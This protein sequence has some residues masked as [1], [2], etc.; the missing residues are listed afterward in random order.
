MSAKRVFWL[1]LMVV[2]C[3]ASMQGQT[4]VAFQG[5]EPGDS[6]SYTAS[7]ASAIGQ[8]EAQSAANYTSGS[9]SIVMGGLT[10][11]GSCLS[12]GSGNG[13][14]ITNILTF[15]EV[16][17]S[18]STN[19]T[20]E[21]TF[22]YGN[23]FPECGGTGF[24]NGENL[25]LIPTFNGVV[26]PAIVVFTGG[27]NATLDIAQTT[28]AFEVPPCVNS[29]SFELQ[30]SLNRN[31]EFLFI[32]DVS[33]STP[34]F[35]DP[36]ALQ[37]WESL[38]YNA[39]TGACEI[40]GSQPEAPVLD[41]NQTAFFNT[42]SC[43][44][45]VSGNLPEEPTALNCWD[46]FLLDIVNCQWVNQGMQPVHPPNLNCW[47]DYLFDSIQCAWVNQGIQPTD[48]AAQNCWDVFTFN[49]ALCQWENIGVQPEAPTDVVCGFTV[50]FSEITCAWEL[51][52]NGPQQ[53]TP[54]HCWDNFILNETTCIWENVGVEPEQPVLA[55]Y[56][57]AV[58][59]DDGCLWDVT[60]DQPQQ[61]ALECYETAVFNEIG[62]LWDVTGNQPQQ[63]TLECYE[64][65]VFDDIGCFWDVFGNQPI[66]PS[67]A[68]YETAVFNDFTCSWEVSGE[69]PEQPS[70]DCGQTASFNSITCSWEVLGAPITL[71]ILSVP[72][73]EF[74]PESA[75]LSVSTTENDFSIEWSVNGVPLST[76]NVF[77]YTFETEGEYIV[78]ADFTS[79][80]GCSISDTLFI[81]LEPYASSLFVP[82]CFT[83]NFDGLN[84]FFTVKAENLASFEMIIFNRWGEQL[85]QTKSIQPGWKGFSEIGYSYPDG[86]YFY[87]IKA[88]GKDSQM[89][90]RSGSVTLIR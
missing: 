16:D 83:P 80:G 2:S 30:I 36:P 14:S 88:K 13:A 25:T 8:A 43:S 78:V 24:D 65:A 90:E 12:G 19:F 21:L 7:G 27:S 50:V 62:C 63:P 57:T 45:E 26:Q 1:C 37:C 76:S 72:E 54:T 34:G 39:T 58:F 38:S 68:C 51:D 46:D 56:E 64:T 86:N 40:I 9:Q 18:T 5:A 44:W 66:E 79:A 48:P 17:I 28:Y 3:I 53:P 42:S 35:N 23:R 60:G 84:D 22:N 87:V 55:C 31:D 33:L 74:A 10:G 85:F 41:C 77:D 6:W 52:A 81:M 59:N 29:F 20:R 67:T 49:A 11:G 15:T 32:D 82:N 61:P 71:N 73:L 75:S 47:D 70:L 89:Y 69:Q 4:V